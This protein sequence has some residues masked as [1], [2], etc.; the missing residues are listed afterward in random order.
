MKHLIPSL[1]VVLVIAN[2]WGEE[3]IYASGLS[4][5]NCNALA[6]EVQADLP[7]GYRADCRGAPATSSSQFPSV[8][9]ISVSRA[10]LAASARA[11]ELQ[12]GVLERQRL[13]NELLRLEIEAFK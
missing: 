2:S 5:D 10:A 7:I 4:W 11:F 12:A 3:W 6:S 9:R 1:F 13:E 8:N